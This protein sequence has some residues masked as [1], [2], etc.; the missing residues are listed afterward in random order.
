VGSVEWHNDRYIERVTPS[1]KNNPTPVTVEVNDV[2]PRTR[3]RAKT[4]G[5]P[6][7]PI[8]ET[9]LDTFKKMV[10][11]GKLHQADLDAYLK[12]Q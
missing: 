10:K 9:P 12:L 2:E 1:N 8:E 5:I 11:D 3:A 6:M 7:P 4:M